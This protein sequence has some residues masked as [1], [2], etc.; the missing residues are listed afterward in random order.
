MAITKAQKKKYQQL[1]QDGKSSAQAAAGA[2]LTPQQAATLGGTGGRGN[3]T[4]KLG[5]LNVA[6]KYISKNTDALIQSGL[7]GNWTTSTGKYINVG[8]EIAGLLDLPSSNISGT[9][10]S[11]SL[12]DLAGLVIMFGDPNSGLTTQQQKGVDKLIQQMGRVSP[13]AY[14]HYTAH[15]N[16]GNLVSLVNSAMGGNNGLAI[17][18][19]A[20][21]RANEQTVQDWSV[22]YTPPPRG[23]ATGPN[24]WS[25]TQ[26]RN[27]DTA[28]NFLGYWSQLNTPATQAEL[29]RAISSGYTASQIERA[30]YNPQSDSTGVLKQTSAAF[31]RAFPALVKAYRTQTPIA[32]QTPAE[33]LQLQNNYQNT[34]RQYGMPL[35]TTAQMANMMTNGVTSQNLETRAQLAT[36]AYNNADPAVKAAIE[37]RFGLTPGQAATYILD[38][39]KGLERIKDQMN[40]AT[41][42]VRG[43][44]AG[45]AQADT[46]KLTN[47]IDDPFS[48]VSQE[49]ANTAIDKANQLSYLKQQS[50]GVDNQ[51]TVTGAETVGAQI[52]QFSPD[53]VANQQKVSQ[54]MQ[55]R[56]QA[57]KAGGQM[58][59]DQS[60]VKGAGQVQ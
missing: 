56:E 42:Q 45:L 58:V 17:R 51:T 60:G 3:S 44:R 38:P 19:Y 15:N 8:P 46:D 27:Y 55:E 50:Y 34:M 1:I 36:Q 4:K 30:L 14:E 25:Y 37:S 43:A 21:P 2:G 12:N 47:L 57:S 5:L 32:A 35:L 11:L 53:A 24:G 59:T 7:R 6:Q 29:T 54:A 28:S 52:P 18:S 22:E 26:L 31:Q 23:N 40:S 13:T 10:A 39:T 33:Y 41:M 20:T 49:Q 16:S 9:T 48:G